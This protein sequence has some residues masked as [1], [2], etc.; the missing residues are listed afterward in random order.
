MQAANDSPPPQDPPGCV[1]CICYYSMNNIVFLVCI[2]YDTVVQYQ[3]LARV[4]VL[5]YY[6]F[7]L[8]NIRVVLEYER[9]HIMHIMHTTLVVCIVIKSPSCHRSVCQD[10]VLL[11][12]S[13]ALHKYTH[14]CINLMYAYYQSRVVIIFHAF[15]QLILLASS[16]M[17]AMHRWHS[18]YYYYELLCTVGVV[19]ADRCSYELV[20]RC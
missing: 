9:M 20:H 10:R 17:Y 16:S 3:L 13:R 6:V 5:L 19:S 11:S 14:G 8:Y 1:I 15:Y 7:E 12:P 2:L 18:T 4:V